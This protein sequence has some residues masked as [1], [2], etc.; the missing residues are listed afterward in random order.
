MNTI[1]IIAI[2]IVVFAFLFFQGTGANVPS[3]DHSEIQ[4]LRQEYPKL[5]IL[6]VRTPSE[7]AS[8]KMKGAKVINYMSPDFS[9]K[10]SALPKD[11]AYLVYCRSG[12]RSAGA[13]AKMLQLGFAEV[14][15]LRGG[16]RE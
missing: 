16:Y 13:V 15:N 9:Q 12:R 5:Q 2:V 14:Y 4:Q 7:A 1:L 6:D 3:I 10:V 11:Q 8:G